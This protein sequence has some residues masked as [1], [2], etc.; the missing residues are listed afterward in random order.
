[1]PRLGLGLG[2]G[3]ASGG[4]LTAAQIAQELVSPT[5]Q[6]HVIHVGDSRAVAMQQY[7][8]AH[9]PEI[10]WSGAAAV[11]T[12]AAQAASHASTNRVLALATPTEN[13]EIPGDIVDAWAVIYYGSAV[14]TG[15]DAPT[16][17]A[18]QMAYGSVNAAKFPLVHERLIRGGGAAKWRAVYHKHATG[19]VGGDGVR[20]VAWTQDRYWTPLVAPAY[21]SAAITDTT[22]TG[23]AIA[24][25]EIPAGFDWA[26]YAA[27][28]A[29]AIS[30]MCEPGGA[31]PAGTLFQW[32]DSP[33]L[34]AAGNGIVH[35]T[36]S[37]SGSRWSW[38][39]DDDLHPAS[40][41]EALCDLY[42]PNLILWSSLG[43]NSWGV[44]V[45]QNTADLVAFIAK[46]RALYPKIPIVLD[47]SYPASFT[48]DAPT[49]R[50]AILAV[51]A[52][53]EGVLVLDSYALRTY[54]EA[55]ALWADDGV[56]YGPEGKAHHAADLGALVLAAA[57]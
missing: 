48:G 7:F 23:L 43:V 33:W 42:G 34:E 37:V 30:W 16:S 9:A 19:I 45:E 35:H 3:R 1:M 8:C 56:H 14:F 21:A 44:S 36:W 41:W 24:E 55:H 25:I 49:W 54:A 46:W 13:A 12:N 38:W 32:S 18:A 40:K 2:L 10:A 26:A 47:T 5:K 53:T 20:L 4:I 15:A 17:A 6:W 31:N 52:V 28:D 39:L 57:T 22:G 50:A 51:A 29:P 11:S 27:L